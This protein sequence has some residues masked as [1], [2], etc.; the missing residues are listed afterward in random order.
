M[1]AVAGIEFDF[2]HM[3]ISSFAAEVAANSSHLSPVFLEEDLPPL[4]ACESGSCAC[5]LP[6]QQIPLAI[7]HNPVAPHMVD[8]CTS[9]SAPT[10]QAVVTK[11]PCLCSCHDVRIIHCVMGWIAS[12]TDAQSDHTDCVLTHTH[13]D[14]LSVIAQLE[15]TTPYGAWPSEVYER[16]LEDIELTHVEYE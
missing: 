14:I 3:T 16:V 11:P 15:H 10:E 12:L 8:S 6:V 9:Q 7:P 4:C 5:L 1:Q 2:T 13:I